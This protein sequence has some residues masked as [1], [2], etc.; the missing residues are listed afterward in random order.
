MSA[1]HRSIFFSAVER[2]GGF[3]LSVISTAAMARLLT[4]QEFGIFAVISA[5]VAVITAFFQEFGGANYLIQ[6]TSLST[7]DIRTAFTITFCLSSMVGIALI[8]TGSEFANLFQQQALKDGIAIVALNFVL[9]PIS[10]TISALFRRNMEFGKLA[11]CNLAANFIAVAISIALAIAGY[12]YLAPIWGL[13]VSNVV[14]S[15]LLVVSWGDLNIFRPSL[16]GYRKVMSFGLYSSGIG[17]TNVFYNLA[18]QLFLGRILDFSAVGLYSRAVGV[19]QLF[20]KLVSQVLSPVI[21]PAIFSQI[22]AGGDLKQIYL[23]ALA[24]LSAVHWP[25][26]LF[27]GVM[28]HPIILI[29][30]GSTWLD[31]VPLVR[32]LCAGDLFL[33]AACLTYPILVAVGAV[34]SAMIVSLISLPPSILLIFV[35]SFFGV[36]AVA[37]ASLLTLPFQAAVAFF[38]IAR[39]LN[40]PL[41]DLVRATWKSGIV[42]FVS[43]AGPVIC[44]FMI[45]AGLLGPIAGLALACLSAT[46]GWCATLALTEHPL[47][48]RLQFAAKALA[49]PFSLFAGIFKIKP[50]GSGSDAQ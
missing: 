1:V 47:L 41:S 24:L 7:R 11:A 32:L 17:V 26:L 10:V 4:P 39:H 31:I 42:T 8:A 33:F 20:D 18:P 25:F 43:I 3:I 15:A 28:A 37:A 38:F 34:R 50:A 9:T 35:A 14:L 13:V 2:Y 16:S 21:M 49:I 27:M 29:W 44:A 46:A 12:S 48:S 19:T 40:L 6:K 23:D 45:Q 30:L 5:I 36:M 22:K